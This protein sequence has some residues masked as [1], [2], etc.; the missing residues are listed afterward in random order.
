MSIE[1]ILKDFILK[2]NTGWWYNTGRWITVVIAMF[3]AS[4]DPTQYFL[5]M[6]PRAWTLCSKNVIVA[7]RCSTT[8]KTRDTNEQW[9]SNKD[10][11]R[12]YIFWSYTRHPSPAA[13]CLNLMQWEHSCYQ[14]MATVCGMGT[15]ATWVTAEATRHQCGIPK[16]SMSAQG[17][18]LPP[19]QYIHLF[20]GIPTYSPGLVISGIPDILFSVIHPYCIVIPIYPY[21]S[22]WLKYTDILL[23]YRGR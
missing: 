10:A 23:V 14:K 12:A 8:T 1:A 22:N 13:R 9:K 2:C 11:C 17:D 21:A 19:M 7:S 3:A 4:S 15:R 5:Q 20:P 6:Y 18:A 16:T